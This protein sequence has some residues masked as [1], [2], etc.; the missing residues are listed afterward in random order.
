[1]FEKIKVDQACLVK[2]F[3][4]ECFFDRRLSDRKEV[5][6][7]LKNSI[8]SGRFEVGYV[9]V[10]LRYYIVVN[11]YNTVDG[12]ERCVASETFLPDGLEL[13]KLF[14]ASCFNGFNPAFSRNEISIFQEQVASD[15]KYVR[16]SLPIIVLVVLEDA[17]ANQTDGKKCVV[18]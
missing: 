9:R 8:F 11:F 18:N 17:V 2:H 4:V 3:L 13:A 14:V 12:E 10:D 5:E 16:E 1:L 15:F 7:T 6:M